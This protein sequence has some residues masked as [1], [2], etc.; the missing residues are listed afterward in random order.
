MVC[1][2]KNSEGGGGDSAIW[3]AT[4]E[5][6]PW[7]PL[8]FFPLSSFLCGRDGAQQS[9]AGSGRIQA[10]FHCMAVLITHNNHSADWARWSVRNALIFPYVL[11]RQ[12]LEQSRGVSPPQR[13]AR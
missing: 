4:T 8:L 1:F 9:V 13:S 6:E 3:L 5:V 10:P 2:Q 7:P 12:K 11:E